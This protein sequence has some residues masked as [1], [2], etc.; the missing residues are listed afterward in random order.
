MYVSSQNHQI[1]PAAMYQLTPIKKSYS[2]IRDSFLWLLQLSLMDAKQ[3]MWVAVYTWTMHIPII[4][5][6]CKKATLKISIS[7]LLQNE[8]VIDSIYVMFG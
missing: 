6:S 4:L 2:S 7:D 8:L 5:F 3:N 1:A